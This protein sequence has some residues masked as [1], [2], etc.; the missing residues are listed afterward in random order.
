[1]HA[2]NKQLDKP[3]FFAFRRIAYKE[4]RMNAMEPF[5]QEKAQRVWQRVRQDPAAA[6]E[7][8]LLALI[9]EEQAHAATY[10]QLS[11]RFQGREGAILRQMSQQEQAHAAC[12][13]GIYTLLTGTSPVRRHSSSAPEETSHALRRCYGCEMRCLA[14]YEKKAEDPQ[15]GPVFSRLAQQERE[16]C[17]MLL[18]LIG[19]LPAK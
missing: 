18:E 15:Y 5:D 17:H 12:L 1:M 7:A 13:K 8:E 16:H 11:R 2:V 4:E 10:L 14:A 19:K 3:E 9:S 6:P